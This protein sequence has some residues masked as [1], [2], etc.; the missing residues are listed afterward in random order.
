MAADEVELEALGREKK[1]SDVI[2]VAL[3]VEAA[4]AAEALTGMQPLYA[5][6]TPEDGALDCDAYFPGPMPAEGDADDASASG[7]S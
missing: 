5:S 6:A 1:D 2:A 4:A 3:A 7:L